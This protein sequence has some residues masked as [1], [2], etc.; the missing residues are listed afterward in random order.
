MSW[1]LG[2]PAPPGARVPPDTRLPDSDTRRRSTMESRDLCAGGGRKLGR[3]KGD[4]RHRGS[5]HP[6]QGK[7]RHASPGQRTS[8]TSGANGTDDRVHVTQPCH[9]LAHGRILR[10]TGLPELAHA[11][12]EMVLKL[13]HEAAALQPPTTQ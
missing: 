12:V 3:S 9:R 4:D 8:R 2:L 13:P 5:R 6:G 1:S 11:V 7:A 10:H